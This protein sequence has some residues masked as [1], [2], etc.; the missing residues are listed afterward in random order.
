MTSLEFTPSIWLFADN[1]D[2]IGQKLENDPMWQ[3]EGHL[4]HDF[5]SNF[6]ASIDLLYRGGFQSKIDGVDVGDELDYGNLGLTLSYNITD[7]MAIR[8]GYN[9]NVFG[10]DNSMFRLQFVY[11]WHKATEDTKKLMQ[12]H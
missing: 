10:V 4:T 11:A 9:T 1:D 3:L 6:F 2:F 12:G 5:T 8:T 7:N